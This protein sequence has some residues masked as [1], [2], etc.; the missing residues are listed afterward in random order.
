[1]DLLPIRAGNNSKIT[2]AGVSA[3]DVS[4]GMEPI[5]I[6]VKDSYKFNLDGIVA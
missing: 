6:V 1:M 3:A 4:M 2:G 5:D